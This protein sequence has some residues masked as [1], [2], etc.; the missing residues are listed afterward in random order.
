MGVRKEMTA[1]RRVRAPGEQL[2]GP[3]SSGAD[4]GLERRKC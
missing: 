2:G 4:R 1:G 3:E